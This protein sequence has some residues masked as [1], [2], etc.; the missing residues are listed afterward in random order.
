[1]FITVIL[2]SGRDGLQK[3]LEYQN[4]VQLCT[5]VTI[6]VRDGTITLT[7]KFL[8]FFVTKPLEFRFLSALKSASSIPSLLFWMAFTPSIS[9]MSDDSYNVISRL[10]GN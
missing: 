4:E 8:H 3:Y 6:N 10:S 1:M 5:V 2:S 9:S 7:I